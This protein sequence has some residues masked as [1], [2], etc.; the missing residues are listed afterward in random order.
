MSIL[1]KLTPMHE[2]SETVAAIVAYSE[3]TSGKT[4]DVCGLTA[5]GHAPE[6]QWLGFADHPFT[7]VAATPEMLKRASGLTGDA[8]RARKIAMHGGSK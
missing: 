3:S 7:P 2:H 5:W 1:K 8:Y 4:C 6:S